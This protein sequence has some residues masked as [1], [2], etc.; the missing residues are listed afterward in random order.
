MFS[1]S[2]VKAIE[3]SFERSTAETIDYS[4][5]INAGHAANHVLILIADNDC[6]YN[7]CL[8]QSLSAA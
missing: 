5:A 3:L 4:M 7:F 6:D 8:V 2:V 1:Q